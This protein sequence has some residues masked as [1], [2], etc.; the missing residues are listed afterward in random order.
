[1]F[2]CG[3]IQGVIHSGEVFLGSAGKKIMGSRNHCQS[4][5]LSLGKVRSAGFERWTANLNQSVRVRLSPTLYSYSSWGHSMRSAIHKQYAL[6]CKKCPKFLV[7]TFTFKAGSI[8]AI[9]AKTD[10]TWFWFHMRFLDFI[11]LLF[12]LAFHSHSISF[13]HLDVKTWCRF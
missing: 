9:R 11:S 12:S 2:G 10:T 1:M 13:I 8:T 4:F 7:V 3:F 5:S 6:C